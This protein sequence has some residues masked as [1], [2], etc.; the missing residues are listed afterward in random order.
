MEKNKQQIGQVIETIYGDLIIS[1]YGEERRSI[2]D[3]KK[4]QLVKDFFDDNILLVN[5]VTDSSMS[6]SSIVEGKRSTVASR[7]DSDRYIQITGTI[8]LANVLNC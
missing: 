6:L 3:Y 4:G 5:Y 2:T 7:K 1:E 8:R